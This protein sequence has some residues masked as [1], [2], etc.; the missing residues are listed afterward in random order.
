[1]KL[2]VDIKL[3]ERRPTHH[4]MIQI[5]KVAPPCSKKFREFGPP[6]FDH[7]SRTVKRNGQTWAKHRFL[8]CFPGRFCCREA[9]S[10]IGVFFCPSLTD[11]QMMTLNFCSHN[12]MFVNQ[13]WM[14]R[15]QIPSCNSTV[16]ICHAGCMVNTCIANLRPSDHLFRFWRPFF[17][18][19]Y[20]DKFDSVWAKLLNQPGTFIPQVIVGTTLMNPKT[21]FAN[22]IA[23]INDTLAIC[24][25]AYRFVPKDRPGQWNHYCKQLWAKCRL[26]QT[27]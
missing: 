22:E 20:L 6:R 1:M 15:P 18:G 25:N 24:P 19:R 13:L 9:R 8:L 2:E 7:T 14:T 17:M 21:P 11:Q 27:T 16:M 12:T 3:C 23:T 10:C 26:H 5:K 4:P